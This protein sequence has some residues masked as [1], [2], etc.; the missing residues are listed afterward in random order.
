MVWV[1]QF[2]GEL[3]GGGNKSGVG[4]CLIKPMLLGYVQLE[5]VS[6]AWRQAGGAVLRI[7]DQ[8]C[9]PPVKITTPLLVSALALG[10]ALTAPAAGQGFFGLFGGG[11]PDEEA[12]I[13]DPLPYTIA[14]E[15]GVEGD[16]D[17]AIRN[18]S[19]LWTGRD[20]P[21]SGA[22]GLLATARTDY[23]RITAALY[24]NGYYGGAII[25]TVNG[26]EATTIPPLAD[27]GAEAQVGVRVD[28]GVQFHFGSL[29]IVN[30][31]PMAV[32]EDDIV[33]TPEELGFRTGNVAEADI[34]TR[35]ETALAEAW[36]QLGYAKASVADRQVVADHTTRTLDVV[37]R[38]VPG[39]HASVGPLSVSGNENM[40]PDFIVRQTGLVPGQEYDPDDI[41]KAR[42][43]L[44]RLDVFRSLRI[45]AAEAIP[46]N[47]LLPFE[48]MVQEQ[49]L[50]RFG[51]GA[52]LSTID[53]LGV[54]GFWLHR[55]L[56]G[57]A[58][59]LRLDARVAG[60]GY[61]VDT[62]EFDYL[63]G[64]TFTMPG[65]FTP[66]TDLVARI[67]AERTVLPRYTQTS[68]LAS[69]GLTHMFSD[70]ITFEGG[71]SVKAAHFYDDLHGE[72]DF[73][74]AGVYGTATFDTR[75]DELDPTEGI[76]LTGT[77]EPGYE[78]L[79]ENLIARAT[80]EGRTYFGFG[81]DNTV[82]LAARVRA[83]TLM[84][85]DVSEIPPDL[86][87]FAGGGGSVRGYGFRSIG[88]DGPGGTV[89]GGRYL[90][91][92]SLEARVR[93]NDSFGAVGFVDGGFV[94]N[95]TFP[96]IDD[97]R[98]G[99]GLGVRYYT[100]FGPLRL[101]LAVPLNKREGDPDFGLYVGIGQSF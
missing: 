78:F 66:D 93:I 75:D 22:G 88:V 49:A 13:A 29:Q 99:A 32:E 11:E 72:R 35:A 61:P 74:T 92:G 40:D 86:L 98:I 24:N 53:G 94:A 45:E 23:A 19:S 81:E 1:Q 79:Y 71:F 6:S 36:R 34:I 43:R 55:N 100:P 56:F 4:E 73:V 87:Y 91:E 15:T 21:A 37:L 50:R 46:A 80:V 17:A 16:L 10:L 7:S 9:V 27:L 101:D 59:R 2:G 41:A 83:G 58:E 18:A 63:F 8:D 20:D 85:P 62:D 48:I 84:G 30:R 60:I 77:V 44:N 89:V 47:G 95:D 64:G 31:P 57:H 38:V 51:V 3:A 12:V 68:A 14:F 33:A 54:E 25:I 70:E 28:P 26:R 5:R 67:A 65:L 97:L 76:F 96:T 82:V 39:A 69:V 90:L 52:T 42:E